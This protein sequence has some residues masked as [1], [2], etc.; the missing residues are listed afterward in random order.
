M[1][2]VTIAKY[3]VSCIM[4]ISFAGFISCKKKEI[5]VV[6]D[7]NNDVTAQLL[8]ELRKVALPAFEWVKNEV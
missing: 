3:L 5:P 4:I 2:R 1:K 8:E 6:Y 7:A